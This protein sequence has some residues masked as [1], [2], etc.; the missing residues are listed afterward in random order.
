MRV[1]GFDNITKLAAHLDMSVDAIRFTL[2]RRPKNVKK[3]H[4]TIRKIGETL[5]FIEDY[6]LAAYGLVKPRTDAEW[7]EILEVQE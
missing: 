2:Y 6:W 4:I 5:P 3:C 7:T 1:H